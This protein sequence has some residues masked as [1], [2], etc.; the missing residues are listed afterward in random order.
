MQHLP[1]EIPAPPILASCHPR[2]IDYRRQVR[3]RS[4]W[5]PAIGR[6]GNSLSDR[7]A[8]LPVAAEKRMQVR[9]RDAEDFGPLA[10][11]PAGEG[12]NVFCKLFHGPECHTLRHSGQGGLL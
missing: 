10:V 1:P 6:G 7:Q 12:P 11:C 9:S 8:R 2:G 3:P 5:H 4:Q